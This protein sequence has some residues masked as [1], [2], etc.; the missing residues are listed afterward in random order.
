MPLAGEAW[1]NYFQIADDTT[2]TQSQSP[3]RNNAISCPHLTN[4]TAGGSGQRLS[5]RDQFSELIKAE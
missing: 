3:E 4:L 2:R 5:K 1:Q